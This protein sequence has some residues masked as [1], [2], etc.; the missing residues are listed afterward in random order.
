MTELYDL[1]L[2]TWS[3]VYGFKNDIVPS[4]NPDKVETL[5]H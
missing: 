4:L 3:M 1:G 5:H 2:K